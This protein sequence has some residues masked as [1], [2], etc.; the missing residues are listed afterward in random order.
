VSFTYNAEP[1]DQHIYRLDGVII[2]SLTQMLYADGQSDHLR[3]IDPAVVKAKAE[4]GTAL[5]L[6]LQKMEYGY[7]VDPEYKQHSADWHDLLRK[8][9]WGTPLG[10]P[11]KNC[12]LP[13]LANVQGFVYGFTPDR[14]APEAVIEIKGTADQNVSHHIQTALQVLGMGYPRS[15]PRYIAYFDKTGLKKLVT[16]GPTVKRDGEV[17]DVYAEADRILF[18]RALWMP[19]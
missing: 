19:A 11:W 18:E 8:M 17:L 15:T 1:G 9:K 2:P 5:H 10:R 14:A 3:R 16:C 13:V 12:E 4:W 7:G 6:A